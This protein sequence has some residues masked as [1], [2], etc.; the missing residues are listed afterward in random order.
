M[1]SPSDLWYRHLNAGARERISTND[2]VALQNVIGFEQRRQQL[3]PVLA[4]PACPKL[5]EALTESWAA[6]DAARGLL[7]EAGLSSTRLPETEEPRLFWAMLVDAA[8][9]GYRGLTIDGLWNALDR[10]LGGVLG[11]IPELPST[12]HAWRK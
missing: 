2:L 4:H 11:P 6:G 3:A 1:A 5:L 7:A 8:A 9:H 10:R 12:V